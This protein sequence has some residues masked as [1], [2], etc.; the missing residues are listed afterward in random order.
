MRGDQA[1]LKL[2][3]KVTQACQ[4][5]PS[6]LSTIPKLTITANLPK[7]STFTKAPAPDP[8]LSEGGDDMAEGRHAARDAEENNHDLF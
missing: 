1:Q 5:K 7:K 8:R 4:N 3:F 2:K 6:Q